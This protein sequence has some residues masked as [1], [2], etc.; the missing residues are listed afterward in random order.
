MTATEDRAAEHLESEPVRFWTR[1]DERDRDGCWPY[2]EC[3]M[4]NG[5][6]RFYRDRERGYAY[7]HRVAWE[8]ANGPIPEGG[9][10]AHTCD[11]KACCR[12]AH[13]ELRRARSQ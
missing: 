10:I 8:L 6:G 2:L 7:A 9:R 13:L 12:P 4:W 5:Y 3:V 11:N 1:V